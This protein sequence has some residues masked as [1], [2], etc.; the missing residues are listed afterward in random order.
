MFKIGWVDLS[1]DD[2]DKVMAVIDLMD[3]STTAVDEL[4]IGII[5][6][7]FAD[8]LF[9]G[10]STIQTRSK[11]FFIIPWIMQ[12]LE[13]KSLLTAEVFKAQLRKEELKLIRILKNNE[14]NKTGTLEQ[15]GIIGSRSGDL[16]KRLPSEIY[17]NGLRTYGIFRLPKISLTQYLYLG[18]RRSKE[19]DIKTYNINTDEKGLAYESEVDGLHTIWD[20]LTPQDN[21][22]EHVDMSLTFEEAKFLIHRIQ[23]ADRS[24]DSLLAVL[25]NE[26]Q[27]D[28]N[29]YNQLVETPFDKLDSLAFYQGMSNEIKWIYQAAKNFS[30]IIKGAHIR[31]NYILFREAGYETYAVEEEWLEWLAQLKVFDFDGFD[32]KQIYNKLNIHHKDVRYFISSWVKVCQDLEN[33]ND[34]YMDKL[35]VDREKLIKGKARAKLINA[36]K[37]CEE[38]QIQSGWQVGIDKLDYRWG[39]VKRHIEDI[40]EGLRCRNV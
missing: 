39:N 32:M 23:V 17:W 20:I 15:K 16:L 29:F 40:T 6:D 26:V 9:P 36:K 2:R 14:Y 4:G 18:N 13:N 19:R 31:Y 10:I 12:E 21:W 24:K 37:Y 25:V 22:R 11:Y 1:N 3:S 33:V 28:S 5:R 8:C 7:H 35:I 30:F 34:E 27:K 38:K